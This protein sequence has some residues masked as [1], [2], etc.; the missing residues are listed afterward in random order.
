[1]VSNSELVIAMCVGVRE[2]V[3]WSVC[4][5]R[6]RKGGR[7]RDRQ[8]VYIH[9]HLVCLAL[10]P[11][12]LLSLILFLW[13]ERTPICPPGCQMASLLCCTPAA[14]NHALQMY[15]SRQ[16]TAL[17]VLAEMPVVDITS[18]VT[19]FAFNEKVCLCAVFVSGLWLHL[20][21]CW[22]PV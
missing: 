4:V 5:R 18:H 12:C 11:Y 14:Q 3:C 17:S 19:S 2:V 20:S 10:R 7:E 1:M 22:S 8:K 16:H 6:E 13:R 15:T 21:L 9:T